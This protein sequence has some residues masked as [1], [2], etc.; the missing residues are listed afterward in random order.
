MDLCIGHFY[1][2]MGLIRA[3]LMQLSVREIAECPNSS[4]IFH[5]SLITDLPTTIRRQEHTI[6]KVQ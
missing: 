6:T 3:Q 2:I 5:V 1:I 4:D